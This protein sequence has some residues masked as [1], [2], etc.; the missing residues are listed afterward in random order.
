MTDW[1]RKLQLQPEWDRAS[2]HEIPIQQLAGVIAD[3]LRALAP[4]TGEFEDIEDQKQELAD[5]FESMSQDETL[6]T[7]QF[8]YAMQDLYDWGDTQIAGK[9]FDA[10]KVCWISRF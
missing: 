9:F 5:Q 4:F 1:Q 8:D 3:R 6:T 10:K 7:S 2:E